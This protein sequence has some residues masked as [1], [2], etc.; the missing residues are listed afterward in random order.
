MRDEELQLA[1][2]I[3]LV[4][5]AAV[6]ILATLLLRESYETK[7]HAGCSPAG[8]SELVDGRRPRDPALLDARRR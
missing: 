3:T 1:G 5:L 4:A 2:K 7:K 6:A 8:N